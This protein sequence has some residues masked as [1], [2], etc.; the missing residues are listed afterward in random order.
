[1]KRLIYAAAVGIVIVAGVFAFTQVT[2][3]CNT[4][5]KAG[6][7]YRGPACLDRSD[8]TPTRLVIMGAALVAS[9]GLVFAGRR[10]T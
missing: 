7:G 3:V 4:I 9:S 8:P 2:S 5:V 1:M 6:P 10:T